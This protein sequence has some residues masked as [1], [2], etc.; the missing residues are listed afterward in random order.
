MYECSESAPWPKHTDLDSP[1]CFDVSDVT[2][3]LQMPLHRQS[4]PLREPAQPTERAESFKREWEEKGEAKKRRGEEAERDGAVLI[5]CERERVSEQS[6][7]S[8]DV[9][10]R[11]QPGRTKLSIEQRSD[12]SVPHPLVQ[13]PCCTYMRQ[14][15]D[16]SAHDRSRGSIGILSREF[17]NCRGDRYHTYRVTEPRG[18]EAAAPPLTPS[19]PSETMCQHS[20]SIRLEAAI[21]TE[22]REPTSAAFELSGRE[23]LLPESVQNGAEID[24]CRGYTKRFFYH[25][26][27]TLSSHAR[28]LWVNLRFSILPKDTSEC[29]LEEPGIIPA[30]FW[31]VGNPLYLRPM[32]QTQ[33]VANFPR[34][35]DTLRLSVPLSR[36]PLGRGMRGRPPPNKELK[37]LRRHQQ[38]DGGSGSGQGIKAPPRA[39]GRAADKDVS[40]SLG[41]LCHSD[42]FLLPNWLASVGLA[43]IFQFKGEGSMGHGNKETHLTGQSAWH[44]TAVHGQMRCVRAPC[45]QETDRKKKQTLSNGDMTCSPGRKLKQT[46]NGPWSL[47]CS[48][49]IRSTAPP[50]CAPSLS[51]CPMLAEGIV[52]SGGERLSLVRPPTGESDLTAVTQQQVRQ[53]GLG[54]DPEQRCTPPPPPPKGPIGY[55]FQPQARACSSMTSPLPVPAPSAQ[56]E[57]PA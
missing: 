18:S 2:P 9:S 21:H 20:R 53:Q 28:L 31:I 1:A 11:E 56:H 36:P 12:R 40:I 41:S 43:A 17:C 37:L 29:R 7:K 10:G 39:D 51:L 5:G 33:V 42:F 13:E 15:W 4:Y 49:K 8:H 26:I 25:A 32:A 44:Q 16:T 23:L 34:A 46:I 30:T 55:T 14:L 50:L 24:E 6:W 52:S 38:P 19:V 47:Q 27:H 48:S 22:G 57:H 3:A 54:K 45:C 35:R